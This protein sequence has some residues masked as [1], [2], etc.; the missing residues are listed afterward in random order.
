MFNEDGSLAELKG[1]EVKRR[2]ELQL[3]K[4]FQSSVFEAFLNG[5]TLEECYDSV[6]RIADYWLDVLYSQVQWSSSTE[7]FKLVEGEGFAAV[8]TSDR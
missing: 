6:A 5:S 1:F 2:G 7:D 4:N 8:Y 3:V